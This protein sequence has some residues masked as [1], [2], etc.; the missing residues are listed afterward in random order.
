MTTRKQ[1]ESYYFWAQ[2]YKATET[3][4]KKGGRATLAARKNTFIFSFG[5]LQGAEKNFTQ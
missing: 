4:S 3:T 5:P 2:R 1:S